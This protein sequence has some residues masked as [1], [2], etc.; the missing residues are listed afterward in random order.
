MST[1]MQSIAVF[2]GGGL[3]CIVRFFI[4]IGFSRFNFQLPLATLAANMLACLLFAATLIGFNHKPIVEWQRLFI[5]TGFCGGLSTFST[6]SFE[7]FEL[8]RN[9]LPLWALLNVLISATLC[10]LIFYIFGK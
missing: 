1:L 3:G 7:T 6:F 4:G 2:L 5:I 9:G 8:I 10:L